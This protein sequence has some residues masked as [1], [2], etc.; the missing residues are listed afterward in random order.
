MS[1]PP[2]PRISYFLSDSTPALSPWSGATSLT[3]PQHIIS[4]PPVSPGS[5]GGGE[6][7]TVNTSEEGRPPGTLG[8]GEGHSNSSAE[9]VSAIFLT[10][11]YR[12]ALMGFL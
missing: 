5:V 12:R 8:T 7:E 11:F 2:I 6:C 3:S 4:E 1:L 9:F 10:H